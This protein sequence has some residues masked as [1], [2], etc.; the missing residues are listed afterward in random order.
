M[1]SRNPKLALSALALALLATPAMAQKLQ[2]QSSQT[3]E[4]Q[5]PAIDEVVVDGRIVGSD[6][7]LRIRS[8]LLRDY[9]SLEGD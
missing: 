5:G 3:T 1:K 4:F 7:D 6:P 8:E 9:S 2:R